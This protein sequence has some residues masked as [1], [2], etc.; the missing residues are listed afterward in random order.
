M[1]LS[2]HSGEELRGIGH[3]YVR[4][5]VRSRT[6][7]LDGPQ[8]SMTPGAMAPWHLARYVWGSHTDSYP[9][10]GIPPKLLIF[11]PFH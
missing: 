8:G 9:G 2:K 6:S 1:L 4:R 11:Q 5:Y 3:I 7:T 10:R